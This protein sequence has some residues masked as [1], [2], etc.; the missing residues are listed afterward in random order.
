MRL[1]FKKTFVALALMSLFGCAGEPIVQTQMIK[2]PY[3]VYCKVEAPTECKDAY[4]V[5]R[6]STKDD[7]SFNYWAWLRPSATGLCRRP[8]ADLADGQL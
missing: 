7:P 4:A 6:V 8:A 5:D 3:P 1:P 2:K